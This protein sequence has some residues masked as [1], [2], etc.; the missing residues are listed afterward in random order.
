LAYP[1]FLKTEEECENYIDEWIYNI[2]NMGPTQNVAFTDRR[3]IFR[4]L[5]NIGSVAA[6]SPEQRRD[7]E[8]DLKMARDYRAE[9]NGA[10]YLG[11]EE[12]E[13]R[14]IA[15]GIIEGH[16]KGIVEGRA[17]GIVE[18]IAQGKAQERAALI[19]KLRLMGLTEEQIN[20][21]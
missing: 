11:I 18:G 17:Q 16:A 4:R 2:K 3:E 12:G 19:E 13:A 20:S 7:Y 9:L 6:L 1:S 8:A 10:R 14:G 21:L 5:E 15:K